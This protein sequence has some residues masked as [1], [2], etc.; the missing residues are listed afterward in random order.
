[1]AENE[2]T[3]TCAKP[4]YLR[5]KLWKVENGVS[6]KDPPESG[7]VTYGPDEETTLSTTQNAGNFSFTYALCNIVNCGQSDLTPHNVRCIFNEKEVILKN[8]TVSASFLPLSSF[9]F[10]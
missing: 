6:D 3:L 1:M 2:T 9:Y 7:T 4:S 5:M 10:L 8:F